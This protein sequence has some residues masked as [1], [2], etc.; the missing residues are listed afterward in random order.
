VVARRACLV[1]RCRRGTQRLSR[2]VELRSLAKLYRSAIE[3]VV[4]IVSQPISSAESHGHPASLSAGRP[5]NPAS[6]GL[7]LS[8]DTNQ[9]ALAH[10]STGER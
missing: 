9:S 7:V 10:A 4:W 2:I 8:L 5:E 1:W 3:T 6:R